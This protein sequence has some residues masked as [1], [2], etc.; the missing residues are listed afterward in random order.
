MLTAIVQQTNPGS[1]SSSVGYFD[2]KSV[3]RV[4][5]AISV[6]AASLFM[7]GAILSLYF[8]TSRDAKLGMVAGFTVVFAFAVAMLT[9]A[10]RAE[11][12]GATAAYAAVL[13]VFVSGDLGQAQQKVPA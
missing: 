2:G 6:I 8:V 3:N 7:I 5:A 12:F 11:M 4:A 9:N 13:V 10:R 1:A